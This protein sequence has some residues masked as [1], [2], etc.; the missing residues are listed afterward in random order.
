M[1]SE[2]HVNSPFWKILCYTDLESLSFG[3]CVFLSFTAS[4]I[5]KIQLRCPD[6]FYTAFLFLQQ[7]CAILIKWT[8]P[9]LSVGRVHCHFESNQE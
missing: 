5:N 9:S 8:C 7:I 2:I 6:V 3:I 1:V 4:Q